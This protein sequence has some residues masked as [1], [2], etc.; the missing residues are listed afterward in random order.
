MV[1][2]LGLLCQVL[3]STSTLTNLEYKVFHSS[4]RLRYSCFL[5]YTRIQHS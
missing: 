4:N 1:L 2:S 5:Q 3:S